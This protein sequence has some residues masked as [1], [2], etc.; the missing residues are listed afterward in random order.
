MDEKDDRSYQPATPPY[1]RDNFHIEGLT[2]FGIGEHNTCSNGP[3]DGT[4]NRDARLFW[5]CL[6]HGST[7][8]AA[9][10][11]LSG[12]PGGNFNL[13]GHGN[14]GQVET[15]MGQT[16]P[17]DAGK[18]ILSWTQSDWE[19]PLRTLIHANF[20]LLSIWSCH[21]GEGQDGADLLYSMAQVLG[22]AVRASNGYMYVDDTHIW[23]EN[24]SVWVVATPTSRPTPVPAPT[25]H[26]LELTRAMDTI[27]LRSGG[28][29][30]EIS[31]NEISDIEVEVISLGGR[32]RHVRLSNKE[33]QGLA[34]ILFG[35]KPFTPPGTPLAFITARLTVS[36]GH[37]RERERK[38]FILYNDRM[39][40]DDSSDV[41]YYTLPGVR[42]A[43]G[44]M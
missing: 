2:S 11:L 41:S 26:P 25:P 32:S 7:A 8:Q 9:A 5:N 38:T 6:R 23:F 19:A 40:K 10:N 30:I 37:E 24:N 14:T 22:R 13:I 39:L 31:L 33:A 15:G 44:V 36:F 28:R 16:G 18:I 34:R 1:E 43:L 35:S 42:Q 21:T 12:T 29:D 27:W 3:D 4:L 20:A 17:F